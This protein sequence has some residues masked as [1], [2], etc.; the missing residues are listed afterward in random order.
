MKNSLI[1]ERSLTINATP[2]K[3]WQVLTDPEYI[4]HWDDVPPGFGDN[5]LRSKQD[6]KLEFHRLTTNACVPSDK[7]VLR[8]QPV[9]HFSD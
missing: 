2:A 1:A 7:P 4:R 6:S 3:V 8:L 5:R 9:Q